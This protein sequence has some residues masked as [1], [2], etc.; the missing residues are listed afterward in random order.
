MENKAE[1][2][3]KVTVNKKLLWGIVAAAVVI[4]AIIVG[5]IFLLPGGDDSGTEIRM[6]PQQVALEI[7]QTRQ[8]DLLSPD[9]KRLDLDVKWYSE[10][11]LV[12]SVDGN[13]LVTAVAGG[14]TRVIAVIK[15]N[16]VEHAVSAE[17]SVK[18]GASV[19][20]VVIPGDVTPEWKPDDSGLFIVGSASAGVIPDTKAGIINIQNT[21]SNTETY[22]AATADDFYSN[23]WEITGTI[24]KQDQTSLFLSFGVKDEN[25]KDQWFC[26]LEDH[27]SL[28]RYW[29]WWS[30]QYQNDGKHSVFNQAATSFYWQEYGKGGAVL[31]YKLVLFE[32][33]LRAYFGNE[34]N[35]LKLAWELPLTE[36][37]FGGFAEG[38]AYQIGINTV[39]PCNTTISNIS[40]KIGEAVEKPED[41]LAGDPN[42]DTSNYKY[43]VDYFNG[44][45]TFENEDGK[46]I[47]G[48]AGNT[49]M[50][51][52]AGK[53]ELYA[54]TWE[55][56]G[57]I[58]KV[59]VSKNL[60]LSFGVRNSA[61]KE[62]WYCLYNTHEGV[63]LQPTWNWADS[64]YWFDGRNFA[65][66]N[67]ASDFFW[68]KTD[69]LS[70]KLVLKD[71]RLMAYFGTNGGVLTLAWSV[72]LTDSSLGGYKKGSSYQLGI[73]TVDPCPLNVT[74]VSVLTGSAVKSPVELLDQ[75]GGNDNP[76]DPGT[77]VS[78]YK[79]HI[80]SHNGNLT[81][82]NADGTIIYGGTGNTE[83]H[84]AASATEKTSQAWELSG[85]VKKNDI[86][87][88]LFLSFG[89]KNA[90][91]NAQW[92]CLYN[93]HEGVSLQPTWNWADKA[94]LYD[95][96]Y[97]AFNKAAS[98]FFWKSTDNL[99]FKLV[100]K[101]DILMAYFGTNGSGMTLAWSVDLT[102]SNFGGFTAGSS[103]QLGIYTVDPCAMQVSNI[104]V[105]TGSAVTS[106]VEMLDPNNG[107]ESKNA[108][109]KNED[110]SYTVLGT[111]DGISDGTY[112][113]WTDSAASKFEIV[114][115]FTPDTGAAVADAN[116]LYNAT[117]MSF[118]LKQGDTTILLMMEHQWNAFRIVNGVNKYYNGCIGGDLMNVYKEADVPVM[119][120]MSYA[121][122]L[123]TLYSSGDNG[124]TW[125]TLASNWDFSD[126]FDT[127][128]PVTVGVGNFLGAS[129]R[130]KTGGGT[131][132]DVT[133]TEIP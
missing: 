86:S 21:A 82:N 7:G 120:K 30:N 57:T 91:G 22:F 115:T 69:N 74:N 11:P 92:F 31:N 112:F 80:G 75:G 5:L 4:V 45:Y 17:V 52:A 64:A 72:D 127:T 58:K 6:T 96:A 95:N 40:V 55:I 9:G 79:Y 65:F 63:S 90:S 26:I 51:F 113:A 125:T 33:V 103:Y 1:G 2:Q 81:F 50:F 114:G 129:D 88:N 133:F 34:T 60:V 83:L 78:D 106:P 111:A 18:G 128:Q 19:D 87:S 32:D 53:D 132:S 105:L 122:G 15:E 107:T 110:G 61:G 101:N 10:S 76:V 59:D 67:A 130:P 84:F 89:V 46:I 43:F 20:Q 3:K 99:D 14:N 102:K 47:Y 42:A 29:D 13:G 62:Q 68:K 56:S 27:I 126:V 35:E 118:A 49:E 73:Y 94:Y 97:F 36:S 117:G 121:D 23:A 93:T 131:I 41:Y 38:S 25:G 100:L 98:E 44:D 16:G 116:G 54:K 66:N 71:D 123:V 85:T 37:K 28:Q 108:I 104:S 39:D 12:A 48:G 24:T 70:Y 124:A 77:D 8:L 119:L 109:I